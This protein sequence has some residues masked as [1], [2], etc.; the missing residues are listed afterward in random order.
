MSVT[1]PANEWPLIK[2]YG[3]DFR[4]E[5]KDMADTVNRLG[6]WEWFRNEEPPKDKGYMYWIH[7]NINKISAGLE[8]NQ[9]SGAT[10]GYAMRCMQDIAKNGFKN[11]EKGFYEN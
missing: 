11:W 4:H 7:P 1:P 6:L 3:S 8:D 9:H 5:L 10:F 2:V